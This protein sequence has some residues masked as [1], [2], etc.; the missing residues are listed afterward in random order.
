[1]LLNC[2]ITEIKEDLKQVAEESNSLPGL[3]SKGIAVASFILGR[4]L[5][6]GQAL[7][8]DEQRAMTYFEKVGCMPMN[9][10][11]LYP[12]M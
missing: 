4:C 12:C 5:H 10:Y 6:L 9:Q 3:V 8:K 11:M 1:M 2:R 7:T